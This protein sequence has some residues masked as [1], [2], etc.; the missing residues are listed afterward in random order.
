M[1]TVCENAA[2]NFVITHLINI[3]NLIVF[4]LRCVVHS[5][6]ILGFTSTFDFH[7]KSQT[8]ERLLARF[9]LSTKFL[10]TELTASLQPASEVPGHIEILPEALVQKSGDNIIES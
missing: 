3:V 4:G 10:P 8:V 1:D 5:C 6:W 2:K 9:V 7:R